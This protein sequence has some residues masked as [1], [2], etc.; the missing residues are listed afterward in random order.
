M[1]RKSTQML[2]TIGEEGHWCRKFS[3]SARQVN[4]R[5][6]LCETITSVR[7]EC[8][9]NLCTGVHR[10]SRRSGDEERLGLSETS[11]VKVVDSRTHR[12][13]FER[14]K[15]N[16]RAGKLSVNKGV[17]AMR[18]LCPRNSKQR[19]PRLGGGGQRFAITTTGTRFRS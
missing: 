10:K 5:C 8:F 16:K 18:V 13:F 11:A 19:T 3:I 14:K 6:W 12:W 15:G 4:F 17:S 2:R 9:E 7:R 1:R